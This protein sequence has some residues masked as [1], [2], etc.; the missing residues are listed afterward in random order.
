[1]VESDRHCLNKWGDKILRITMSFFQTVIIKQVIKE[2][3]P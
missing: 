2:K 3:K 1:M